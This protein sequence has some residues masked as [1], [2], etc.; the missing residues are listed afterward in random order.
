MSANGNVMEKACISAKEKFE[1]IGLEKY[2]DIQS[3]LEYVIG[4][5]QYDGNPVGLYEVGEQALAALKEYKE[6][7]PRQVSKK[8]IDDMTKALATK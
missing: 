2:S 3:K 5:Y 7:K 1:K 4:S 8:L 6:E